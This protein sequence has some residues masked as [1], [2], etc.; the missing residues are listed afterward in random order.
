MHL[1]VFNLPFTS[2]PKTMMMTMTMAP[3]MTTTTTVMTMTI[4]TY[5]G[6]RADRQ[7][8]RINL[9]APF[10]ANMEW[11]KTPKISKKPGEIWRRRR[12]RW[13]WRRRW[14]RKVV[15]TVT[16]RK[17]SRPF[18]DLWRKEPRINNE[19]LEQVFHHFPSNEKFG[20]CSFGLLLLFFFVFFFN[21]INSKIFKHFVPRGTSQNPNPM[22]VRDNGS[23]SVN[24]IFLFFFWGVVRG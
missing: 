22:A 19:L 1:D 20:I 15:G 23:V 18:V 16:M 8:L 12:R 24:N 4:I 21:K 9:R 10:R 2:W 7:I 3:A 5:L 14:R 17:E 11:K 13:R 6:S